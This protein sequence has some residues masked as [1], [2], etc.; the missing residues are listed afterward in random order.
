MYCIF[1]SIL[2]HGGKLGRNEII[3]GVFWPGVA[4]VYYWRK[5]RLGGALGFGAGAVGGVISLLVMSGVAGYF[6]A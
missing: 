3:G 1:F 5:K 2:L 6:R 4:G